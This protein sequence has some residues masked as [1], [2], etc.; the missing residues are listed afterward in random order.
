MGSRSNGLGSASAREVALDPRWLPHTYDASGS[1]LTSV[2]VTREQH[3]ELMFLSDE[4]FQ[5]RFPKATYPATE[6]GAHGREAGEAPLHFI[7]HTSFCCST[8]MLR[9]LEVPGRAF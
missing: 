5:G 7:F 9:A 4:H 6:I 3:S 2:H 8:L 1:N